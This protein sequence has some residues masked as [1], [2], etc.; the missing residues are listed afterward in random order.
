MK[1][2]F[3]G[4]RRRHGAQPAHRLDADGNAEQR[5]AA[6]ESE[7]L[8]SRQH[9]RH[10]HRAGMDRAAF[11]R[12][13]E[14]LAVDRR[15]VDER[16]GHGGER[17]GVADRGA[18]PVV[19]AGGEHGFHVIFVAGG[20]GETDDVD[21]QFLAFG[22]HGLRQMRRIERV[23]LLRQMLGNGNFGKLAG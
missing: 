7:P 6:V 18:R 23:N 11:E 14:I 17:T 22:A 15:A 2:R 1:A 12:V 8:A 9:G 13:I 5:R 20:N 10:H 19:V 16:G 3:V 4:E 21:Q